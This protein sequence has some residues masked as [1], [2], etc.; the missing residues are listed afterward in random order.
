MSIRLGPDKYLLWWGFQVC[1]VAVAVLFGE[2]NS[3]F[4]IGLVWGLGVT[5][6]IFL[7]RNICCAHLNP[8]VSVAMVLAGRMGVRRP[9]MGSSMLQIK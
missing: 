7:T 1:S 4:Q 2:Y 5:L 8:A 3:I 6:A 9:E